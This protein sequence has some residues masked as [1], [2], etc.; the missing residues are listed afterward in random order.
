MRKELFLDRLAALGKLTPNEKKLAELFER[1]YHALAFDNLE[2][3]SAK[4]NVSKSAVSRFIARLGYAN[5]H[6]FI[7]ELRD[8]VSDTIDSPLK[9]HEKRLAAGIDEKEVL[10]SHLEEVG[11]NLRETSK[12]LRRQDFTRTLDLLA[13]A[14]RP[15]YL[16]GCATAQHMVSYFYLL[17][18]YI[19]G[20]VTLLD[21]N[22]STIAHRMEA[23]DANAVLFAM[24]FSRYPALTANLVSYFRERGSEVV[25][26]TDRRTCPMLS[27]ATVSLIVHAE[28]AGMF[29]TRCTAIAVMEALLEGM[30][31]RL[32][33]TVGER[34]AAMHDVSRRLGIF[35]RE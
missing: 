25:L 11:A 2:S 15:L 3:V 17:M 23:V 13:D 10:A 35:L 21:G 8:E 6:V 4:A 22:A 28:G 12:R 20:N 18:R 29:K 16:I 27:C 34:Y 24:A 30:A 9:R 1:E 26:L 33:E 32:P 7:R 14:S 5:F 31:E 19:R